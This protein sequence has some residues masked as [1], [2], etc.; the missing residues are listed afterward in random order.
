MEKNMYIVIERFDGS[1]W[2]WNTQGFFAKLEDAVKL[3]K[4]LVRDFP[5]SMFE[6]VYEEDRGEGE[7]EIIPR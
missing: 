2:V 1:G 5:E 6:V 3:K 4:E 7:L